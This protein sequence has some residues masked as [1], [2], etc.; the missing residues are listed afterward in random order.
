M[1][2][3]NYYF[4]ILALIVFVVSCSKN[5]N[6]APVTPPARTGLYVLNQGLYGANNTSFTYYD[7]TTSTPV[8]DYFRNVNGFGLGDT[9]SDFVIYGSKIYIVINNSGYVA[10]AKTLNTVFLDTISFINSG[11]NRGP[12]NII[13][14]GGKIFVSST[15]GTVAVIDTSSLTIQKFITVGSNP[16][17]MTVS[18]NNVYVSNTGAFSGSYDS[19]VSVIDV[20]SLTETKKIVVGINP[21][22]VAADS[23]GNLY[24]VCTGNYG[25]VSPS[26]VKYNLTSD[27]IVKTVDSAYG[28]I[29]YYNN[30]LITTGGYLGAANVGLLNTADLSMLRPSYIVDGTAIVNPYGL[31]VDP[32]TGDLYVDDAKD[33]VSSGQVFCFDKSGN[34]KFSFS[35]SPGINP[36][37]TLV[38]PQ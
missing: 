7:F 3:S 34:K 16:A 6:P 11:T 1:K 36:T 28:A 30:T 35:V 24:V 23:S 33:Y 29:R 27:K 31:D 25:S 2:K 13:A 32:A 12:E 8:T 15:D 14:A 20:N 18:G 38:I 19:T 10:V 21:G 22:S 17:Q 26:L 9:G 4:L 5:N 37:R